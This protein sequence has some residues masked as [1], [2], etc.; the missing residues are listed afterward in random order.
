MAEDV[1]EDRTPAGDDD[2]QHEHRSDFSVPWWIWVILGFTLLMA[3]VI[4]III[5]GG[6]G[7][8]QPLPAAEPEVIVEPATTEPTTEPTTGPASTAPAQ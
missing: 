6:G 5:Q 1:A 3:T 7:T 2:E 4:V 8:P